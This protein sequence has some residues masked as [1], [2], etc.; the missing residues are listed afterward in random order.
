[1]TQRKVRLILAFDETKKDYQYHQYFIIHP[2]TTSVELPADKTDTSVSIKC[3][4]IKE[5]LP[6]SPNTMLPAYHRRVS[7]CFSLPQ[8]LRPHSGPGVGE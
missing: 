1:M 8:L 7:G 2:L 3:P 4:E 5:I 6:L